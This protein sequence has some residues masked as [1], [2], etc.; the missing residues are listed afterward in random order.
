MMKTIETHGI[1]VFDGEDYGSWKKRIMMYLKLKKC[2]MVITREKTRED[3]DEVWEENNL[4]AINYIYSAITNKQ[5]EFVCDKESAYEIIKKFDEMYLKESTALQIVLRNKLEKLKLKD[6]S[7]SATFFSDFEKSVNELKAA[8]AKVEEKEKLNYMLRTL[9]E[10]YSYV[11]D[12]VDTL[13]TEDQTVDY[14]KNKIKMLELKNKETD[15]TNSKSNAFVTKSKQNREWRDP[16]DQGCFT[17]GKFGHYK[18]DCTESSRNSWHEPRRGH[19]RGRSQQRGTWRGSG[20]NRRNNGGRGG[21]YNT[22]SGGQHWQRDQNEQEA[23]GGV[24]HTIV[25][26][27]SLNREVKDSKQIHWLLDSG[28]TD[29]IIN[30]EKYFNECITLK[31]PINVK[32]G[33]GRI[34]KATKIGKVNTLFPVYNK[35]VKV[36]LLNVFYVKEMKQNLIS[37]SQVT[38]RNKIVSTGN[39]SKIYDNLNRLI[40][41]AWKEGKLYKMTSFIYD[42]SEVNV[43]NSYNKFGNM[44]LK[45][46]WHRILGHVNF[47]YLNILCKNQ[48]LDGIPSEIDSEYMKCKVCIENK[49]RN[50]P[51]ENNRSRAKEILEIVHTDLNGPHRNI[52][53][54]GEKYFLTFI[55]DYSKAAKVFTIKS[56]EEVYKCFVEYINEVENKTGKTIKKLRCDNGK[57]YLNNNIYQLVR[58]KGIFMDKCPPYVHELNGTAERYNRSIMDIARCLLAEAKVHVRFWPEVVLTAAYLKNR[59][60]AN[61]I[62]KKTPYEILFG[63]K[64]NA[65]YLRMYGSRVFVR[66]SEQNR[67]SKWDRKADLGILLGY[68]EVGYRVLINNR[69]VIARHVDIV[70]NNVRC[71]GFNEC[72]NSNDSITD[73][74]DLEACSETDVEQELETDKIETELGIGKQQ[75]KEQVQELKRSSREKKRPARYDENY[76][77]NNCIYINYCSADS[78]N[79]FEEAMNCDESELWKQAMDKELKCLNKNKTWKLV[80][81]PKNKKILDVKWVFTKKTESTFKARLVVRGFQ[82]KEVVDDTYS[83]V[84]RMQT[85]KILL[86]YCCQKGLIIEQMDVETAFL[87]GKISSE[88]YVKQPRGYEDGTNKVCKLEKALYGLRESPRTWYECFDEFVKKVGFK[89]SKYDYCLY[90]LASEDDIMYLIIFVDDL[91]IC[92]KNKRKIDEIKKLLSNRFNMKDMGEIKHY[93]GINIDYDYERNVMTL[94]QKSYIESLAKKYQIENSKLY[95]TPMESNLKL[96]QANVVS[97]DVKYR[98]IIGALLY[99]SSGTRPDI[100]FSVNYLSRFQNCYN[101]THYRYALRVLKYLYSTKDLKL[102][103]KRNENTD[104]LDSFVDADWAGDSIDR[105]STSGY[106]VRLF[107]NVIFWKSKKQGSVTKSSTFAEYVALSE[108]VSEIKFMKDILEDF[109]EYMESPIKIFEDNSGALSIAKYGN[110]TKNSKFIEVHYHFVNENYMKGVI[111]IVKIDTEQNLADIFTKSL[112]K[113]KFERFRNMLNIK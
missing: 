109:N 11:G 94:D 24:F 71:I 61:T 112:S 75:N 8:G 7:D 30:N 18:K 28:C 38:E 111:D 27:N 48:L 31:E 101:V 22:H 69:I 23:A 63:K 47:N 54:N 17:C 95:N 76:V 93:L 72:E 81:Q 98:N 74:E 86:S 50:L 21:R 55:D 96:E 73:T 57:E 49:M 16:K 52:G 68:S 32:V 37:Y 60:L 51:F 4:K 82:Q 1:P 46:K 99:I 5:L 10:S 84:A 100:S 88:I 77:Y 12:L 62:E 91:L 87:N 85:L 25:E 33:D 58:E 80:N 35:K 34:L 3:S 107:G 105:K 45:E 83:P 102:T 2:D 113:D 92:G 6:Y 66:V 36:T 59:T 43:T 104:I 110:F 65:K 78:P 40:A 39:N 15:S 67:S 79:N 13:K 106:I 20:Y 108:A 89:R 56:K 44:S 97:N 90:V 14:V 103:F 70:E 9:P 19:V 64:P 29:H 26:V 41:I 42:E 53:M